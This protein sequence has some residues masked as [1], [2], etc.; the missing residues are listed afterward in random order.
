MHNIGKFD[1][2]YV[3][4]GE[5]FKTWHGLETVAGKTI[6]L[7]GE[8]VPNVFPNIIEAR[9]KLDGIDDSRLLTDSIDD[10]EAK[11]DNPLNGWKM[12]LAEHS[13]GLIPL[14]VPKA[15]YVIHQNRMLFDSAMQSAIK[16]C[17]DKDV[18]I[19]T[20]GTLGNLSQFFLSISIRGHD[21][22][23]IKGRHAKQLHKVYLNL[24]SSH[25]G[26]TASAF[27]LAI[28]RMVCQNTVNAALADAIGNGTAS[29]YKHSK[30]SLGKITPEAFERALK[31]WLAAKESYLN[32]LQAFEAVK[33]TV[34]GF[35][36]F[37]AGVFTNEGSDEL[38]T[39][40]FNR[41]GEMVELFQRGKGNHGET[42][43]DGVNAFTEYF[44]SGNGV[45]STK[46]NP[47]KRVASA[48][49]GRGNDWKRLAIAIAANEK[50]FKAASKRGEILFLDKEKS[51][52]ASN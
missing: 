31:A 3:P 42:L 33:M 11:S 49:F 35:K 6:K 23:T 34:D 14:H 9:F 10:D 27:L 19:V 46:V 5:E 1:M 2:V 44:T 51:L 12:I 47:G 7:N 18:Q 13:K 32:T 52:A 30:E 15:G 17:G 41:V 22:F 29:V 16:V 24:V 4:E 26:L 45:G 36:A 38:S 21:S 20:I 39:T 40:S 8:N 50:D 48:N 28:I 43:G 25:N 37:A